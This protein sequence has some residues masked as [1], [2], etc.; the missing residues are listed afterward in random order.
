MAQNNQVA[1]YSLTPLASYS[2][3]P[4]ENTEGQTVATRRCV[5]I[6]TAVIGSESDLLCSPSI[7][8]W[9]RKCG[10]G[11][12]M[13]EFDSKKNLGEHHRN[14]HKYVMDS[15]F[16]SCVSLILDASS[17]ARTRAPKGTGR[18]KCPQCPLGFSKTSTLTKH[19]RQKHPE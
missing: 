6:S 9:P 19:I 17:V 7:E 3:H 11:D 10:L 14:I 2:P 12:C 13:Q 1:R 16:L 15:D 5:H 18:F 8:Q 4:E